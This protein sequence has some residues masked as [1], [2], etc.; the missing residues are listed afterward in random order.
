MSQFTEEA[1]EK[2][3]KQHI[4]DTRTMNALASIAS[5]SLFSFF[6]SLCPRGKSEF[7]ADGPFSQK[8]CVPERCKAVRAPFSVPARSRCTWSARPGVCKIKHGE[9]KFPIKKGRFLALNTVK[10][11]KMKLGLVKRKNF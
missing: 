9:R 8:A 3:V 5:S 7:D 1:K 11:P 10:K 4:Q 6:Y 2:V